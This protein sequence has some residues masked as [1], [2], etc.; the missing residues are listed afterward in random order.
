MKYLYLPKSAIG[1]VLGLCLLLAALLPAELCAQEVK[2]L[3]VKKIK[4]NHYLYVIGGQGNSVFTGSTEGNYLQPEKKFS[5]MHVNLEEED[6]HREVLKAES[7]SDILYTFYY[8]N[9]LLTLEY[10]DKPLDNGRYM[11]RLAA[12]DDQLA[13]SSDIKDTVLLTSNVFRYDFGSLFRNY[14]SSQSGK[15]RRS[16]IF[17]HQ[18]SPDA[19]TALV[20]LDNPFQTASPRQLYFF[21]LDKALT[22][23]KQHNISLP[24]AASHMVLEDYVLSN[25]GKVYLLAAG[26]E[27]SNFKK[28]ATTF[29][30][31]F[32]S[33]DPDEDKLEERELDMDGRFV[34][35]LGLTL[36]KNQQPLLAGLYT[37]NDSDVGLAGTVLFSPEADENAMQATFT[38]LDIEIA[39]KL[40]NSKNEG[41][42]SKVDEYS[43]RHIFT[44]ENGDITFFAEHYSRKIGVGV[45]LSLTRGI[46]PEPQLEDHYGNV[47]AVRLKKDGTPAWLQVISKSQ[48]S[49]GENIMFNSF[50]LCR[51]G[52]TYGLAFNEQVKN[53]SDVKWVE[54][55]P[56]G[57]ISEKLIFD[58]KA[59][60]LRVAPMLAGS[61]ANGRLMLPAARFGNSLLLS[62][63]F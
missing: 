10:D 2:Q 58:R 12:Y 56:K 40:H 11:L 15:W 51:K 32:Y 52:E 7:K 50:A 57:E 31:H 53:M 8:G 48:K 4:K 24:S 23:V 1:C 60:R 36:D 29:G 37:G 46:S 62:I 42:E 28:Q 18:L 19:E 34:T 16:Y 43:I 17:N 9:R 30:Y 47:L 33:Y 6:M 55:S 38:A 14:L 59:D 26:F 44:E 61:T 45:K 25:D 20:M 5:A 27:D 41:N 39:E 63:D 21:T 22:K 3:E 54:L 49:V 35:N 13:F